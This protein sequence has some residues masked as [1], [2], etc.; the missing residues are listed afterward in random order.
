MKTFFLQC[1]LFPIHLVQLLAAG[2]T[3]RP[4]IHIW[5]QLCLS[6]S[7]GAQQPCFGG[8]AGRTDWPMRKWLCQAAH[9][10]DVGGRQ[11]S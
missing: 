10:A 8:V 1:S 3:M 6:Q 5:L 4:W 2:E 11:Q 9:S 7:R